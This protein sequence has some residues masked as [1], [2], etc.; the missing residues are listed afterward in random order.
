MH[1]MKTIHTVRR[2][3]FITEIAEDRYIVCKVSKI[4]LV[5]MNASTSASK[6]LYEYKFS[7]R[8]VWSKL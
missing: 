4:K 7:Q 8:N 5:N 6:K 2:L 3:I 1:D